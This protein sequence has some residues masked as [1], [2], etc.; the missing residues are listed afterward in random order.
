MIVHDV[1][2]MR[3]LLWLLRKRAIT[4]DYHV[5]IRP[6][7]SDRLLRHER[8]HVEQYTRYGTLG[9]LVRYVWGMRKGYRKNP[10]EVEARGE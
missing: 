1:A 5:F 7:V 4:F 10:L 6:P 3:W 2:P 8:I 9:F